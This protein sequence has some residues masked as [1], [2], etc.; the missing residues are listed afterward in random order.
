MLSSKEGGSMG[1][2][3]KI[4]TFP[5]VLQSSVQAVQG[6]MLRGVRRLGTVFAEAWSRTRA[7][8]RL[9]SGIAG[10]VV[11]AGCAV[12][13]ALSGLPD[14]KAIDEALDTLGM[15]PTLPE[16]VEMAQA[17]PKDASI[18]LALGHAYFEAGQR[19]SA[20]KAYDKALQLDETA[21]DDRMVENLI[22]CYGTREIG[23]AGAIITRYEL[24]DG[25]DGLRALVS[26]ESRRIRNGA[27]DT[28]DGLKKARRDD[29]L[30]VYTL[31][32]AA[33]DCDVRRGAVEKLGRLGDRRALDEIRAA[34]RKDEENTPWYAFSC[35]GDRPRDAEQRILAKR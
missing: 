24:V 13:L 8:P 2:T 27:L 34:K 28:L 25:E 12:V 21:S 15:K 23:A 30:T 5:Q 10:G 14:P 35:L 11:V 22:S 19:V 9:F 20:L 32:L 26:N 6:K 29:F 3:H 7:R 31:D 33:P 17:D 1:R 18:Q 16:L 4:Q